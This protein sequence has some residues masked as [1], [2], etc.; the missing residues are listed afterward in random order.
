V[1]HDLTDVAVG[2]P[3][4]SHRG[5]FVKEN[6]LWDKARG[7]V[8]IPAVGWVGAATGDPST[9]RPPGGPYASAVET[10]RWL[11]PSKLARRMGFELAGYS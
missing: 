8:P 2:R 10:A 7:T 3:V 9:S 6:G 4:H 5:G 1:P 11:L